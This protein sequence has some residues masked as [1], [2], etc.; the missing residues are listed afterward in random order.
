MKIKNELKHLDPPPEGD[1]ELMTNRSTK[2]PPL[3]GG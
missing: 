1:M 2:Y 3:R